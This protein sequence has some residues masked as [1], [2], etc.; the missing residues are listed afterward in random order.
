MRAGGREAE[1]RLKS[2]LNHLKNARAFRLA[3]DHGD[4]DEAAALFGR[5]AVKHALAARVLIEEARPL[6]TGRRTSPSQ[7]E[8]RSWAP[9]G[10]ARES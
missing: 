3:A 8:H 1:D 7:P 4:D 2:A 9:R 6:R 10:S 5:V